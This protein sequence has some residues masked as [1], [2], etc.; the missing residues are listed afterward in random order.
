MIERRLEKGAGQGA[1]ATLFGRHQ[2]T[3]VLA[4]MYLFSVFPNY[5]INNK[6]GNYYESV[7][8]HSMLA[9][10][11]FQMKLA[12]NSLNKKFFSPGHGYK[13]HFS[14]MDL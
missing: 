11:I 7:M 10:S 1:A 3:S 6:C 13:I 8:L 2:I 4:L 9:S 5:Y 14:T 12:Y